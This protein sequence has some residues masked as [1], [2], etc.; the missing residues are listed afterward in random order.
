MS[1]D[2]IVQ[3]VCVIVAVGAVLGSAALMPALNRQRRDLQLTY[4]LE[5]GDR[6]PPEY[7]LLPALGSLRGIFVDILWYR[8]EM[9][10]REGKFHESKNISEF[11]TKLQPRFP[12][13]WVYHAWNLAFNISVET[14]TPEERWDWVKSGVTLLRDQGLVYNPNSVQLYKELGWQLFFKLGKTMDDAHQYYKTRWAEEWHEVLGEPARGKVEGRTEES[15]IPVYEATEAFAKIAD[16]A[17]VYF[18]GART[19]DP[20]TQFVRDHPDVRSLVEALRAAG[21]EFN[22]TGLR[23]IGRFLALEPYFGDLRLVLDRLP[24]DDASIDRA[25]LTIAADSA[26]R[27]HL[28]TMLPFW[29]AKAL[30][31]DYHMKP[32]KMLEV[33]RLYG[34]MDWRH[35]AAHAAYF[36]YMGVQMAGELRNDN[37]IDILNTARGDIHAT[38]LLTDTGNVIYNPLT[39]VLDLLPDPRFIPAYDIAWDKAIKTVVA[40]GKWQGDGPEEN[41]ASG[42][43]NF[44]LKAMLFAYFYGDEADAR[45]YFNK[46]RDLYGNQHHNVFSGRYNKTLEDLILTEY[47]TDWSMPSVMLAFVEGQ[48]QL[49]IVNGLRTGRRDVFNRFTGFARQ[50]YEKF[51]KEYDYTNV[52]TGDSRMALARSWDELIANVYTNVMRSPQ[53]PLIERSRIWFNT[54]PQLQ[55]S[56]YIQFRGDVRQQAAAQGIDFQRAFPPPPGFTEPDAPAQTPRRDNNITDIERQ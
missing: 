18:T 35:P 9:M 30:I 23:R 26:L 22:A 45:R 15:G 11:I 50:A 7:A 44:L 25:A 28:D 32:Q 53:L 13:V 16:A 37:K 54:P 2:R 12:D 38:Q 46:A 19:V 5:I 14:Y 3:L 51:R 41:F 1:R 4:G 20:V 29:R 33:M 56:S 55:L 34:P 27:P 40:Q 48:V 36:G 17:D 31:E 6:L 39:G 52:V 49:G 21:V 43:E 47:A 8:A 42:H 24:A 10:K